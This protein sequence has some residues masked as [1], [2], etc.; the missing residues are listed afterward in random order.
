MPRHNTM[1]NYLFRYADKFGG[2][3]RSTLMQCDTDEEALRKARDT[4]QD[5]YA[6]LEVFENDRPV[7]DPD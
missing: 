6:K 5:G 3:I 7:H 2:A 4:M 1:P